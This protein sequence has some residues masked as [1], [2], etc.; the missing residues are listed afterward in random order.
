MTWGMEE[1]RKVS[2]IGRPS[3]ATSQLWIDVEHGEM[4]LLVGEEKSEF[5]PPSKHTTYE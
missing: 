3:F 4:T 1:D 2:S 5:Q